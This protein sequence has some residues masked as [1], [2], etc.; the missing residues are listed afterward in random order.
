MYDYTYEAFLHDLEHL[1]TQVA[2]FDPQIVLAVARGGVTLG[3]FLSERLGIR[4]LFT[5]NSIHYDGTRKMDRVELFNIPPLPPHARVLLVD[6]IVDSG[7]TLREILS[8]L[9][10]RFPQTHFKSATLFTK[11]SACIQPDYSC[12]EATEWIRF[13]WNPPEE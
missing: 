7:E 8:R 4:D 5:L 10:E 9:R 3:H 13:F 1:C 11:P 12:K 6:D 2:P